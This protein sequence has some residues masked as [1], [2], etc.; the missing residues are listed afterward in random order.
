VSWNHIYVAM[1][2]PQRLRVPIYFA[3]MPGDKITFADG[4]IVPD[5]AI[6]SLFLAAVLLAFVE[7]ELNTAE[8]ALQKVS[9]MVTLA[10]YISES[11]GRDQNGKK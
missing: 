11:N 8:E 6:H 10:R 4:A 7:I 1:E 5:R 3:R 2:G 9:A